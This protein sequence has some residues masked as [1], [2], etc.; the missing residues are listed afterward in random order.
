VPTG[1]K[2]KLTKLYELEEKRDE[3]GDRI[4]LPLVPKA[5]DALQLYRRQVAVMETEASG[6]FLSWLGKLPGMA[7]RIATNLEHL[8]WCGDHEQ[9]DRPP[10]AISARATA[11]AIAFLDGYAT[12][13]ARRCFG[14]ATLPQVDRDAR[15]LARWIRAHIS[16]DARPD[17]PDSSTYAS[18]N[19]TGTAARGAN[20]ANG[21][22]GAKISKINARGLRHAKVLH[23]NETGRY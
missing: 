3:F 22:N 11:A 5:A 12:P 7:V 23:T 4:V 2:A 13:T 19:K 14:E 18:E 21:A 20:G 1:A 17:S 6:L 8:Y 10:E 15:M 16:Q 9:S